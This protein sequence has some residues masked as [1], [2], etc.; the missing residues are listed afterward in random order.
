M[1]QCCCAN[2][3]ILS[4]VIVTVP[5]QSCS[6]KSISC[7]TVVYTCCL[8]R[9]LNEERQSAVSALNESDIKLCC[10]YILA[11]NAH[12]RPETICHSHYL[13]TRLFINQFFRLFFSDVQWRRLSPSCKELLCKIVLFLPTAFTFIFFF[14]YMPSTIFC[15]RSPTRVLGE[16]QWQ[17]KVVKKWCNNIVSCEF[18]WIR[19]TYLGKRLLLR[20]V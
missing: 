8:S 7:S 11:A 15:Q 14:L 3:T 9:F 17:Q 18:V 2:F 10:K 16:W 5:W 19:R 1:R 20:A 12:M 6:L 4:V 13:T